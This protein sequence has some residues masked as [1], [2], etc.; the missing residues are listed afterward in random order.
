MQCRVAPLSNNGTID[1]SWRFVHTGGLNLTGV[2][3][4]YSLD[5][6]LLQFQPLHSGRGELSV[7][8]DSDPTTIS[9]SELPAGSSYIF[10]VTSS[11][12]MGN[13]SSA[14]PPI[15]HSVGTQLEMIVEIMWLTID[16]PF[17]VIK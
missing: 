13:S 16:L 12:E 8:G 7:D 14:C 17:T 2:S 9:V 3:V 5:T 15:S 6:D 10:K 1:V 11:N 4:L